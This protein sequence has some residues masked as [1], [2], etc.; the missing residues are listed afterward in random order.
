M[1]SID[2]S[3]GNVFTVTIA[4]NRILANPTNGV[5]GQRIT[6]EVTQDATGGRTLSFGT[7]FAFSTNLP[8]PVMSTSAGVTDYLQFTY[9]ST[10]SQWRLVGALM[11]DFS[12]VPVSSGGTGATTTAAARTNL[13]IGYEGVFG[14][15]S[16][17]SAALN[18]SSTYGWCTLVGST[19][20][21]NR[22]VFLTSLQ[23]SSGVT[24][25]PNGWRIFCQGTVTN[26]GTIS[27]NGN[28]ASGSTAGAGT[29]GGSMAAGRAGGNGGTA[30]GTNANGL[31]GF[32]TAG[33]GGAGASGAG[34]NAGSTA[35][36]MSSACNSLLKTPSP[37]LNCIFSIFSTTAYLAIPG[38]GGGGGDSTNS[39]GGGGS[40][41]G[42]V[43][44]L[45]AAV[46]NSG[47]ITCTGGNGASATT[48]NC[49]GGGGGS[50]GA[51]LIYSL[52]AWLNTGT[53]AVTAG[54]AGS[55]IGTGVAGTAGSAGQVLNVIVQ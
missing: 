41:G 31:T 7:A 9:S 54:T 17:L 28:N 16:D 24:L 47:S 49:G 39:G 40:G 30:A 4:G 37:A 29:G 13:G 33:A 20:T 22:D 6:V 53:T 12:A 19:Y 21:M 15:G 35:S 38:G 45:A 23:I 50:G 51:I 18:G 44:I 36:N 11:G 14:D 32:G 5:N 42:I 46:A 2:A 43:T 1:I 48:G 8:Q 25:K 55:G 3:K 26:A 27:N 10:T 52:S 34:G